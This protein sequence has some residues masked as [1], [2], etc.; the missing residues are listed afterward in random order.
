MKCKKCGTSIKKNETECK[1][2]ASGEKAPK[3]IIYNNKDVKELKLGL[4][5]KDPL[6]ISKDN[7]DKQMQSL[8]FKM[9]IIVAVLI[10]I[11]GSFLIYL[12]VSTD[13]TKVDDDKTQVEESEKKEAT[14]Y[15]RAGATEMGYI[16]IPENWSKNEEE[17]TYIYTNPTSTDQALD[18]QITF[19][20]VPINDTNVISE[21]YINQLYADKI[22]AIESEYDEQK[23]IEKKQQLAK[24]EII[25][26]TY[27][28]YQFIEYDKASNKTTYIWAVDTS[29]EAKTLITL[30]HHGDSSELPELIRSYDLAK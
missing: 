7:K 3:S 14:N 13:N 9:L 27:K 21:E 30:T 8:M 20:A 26:E 17:G 1:K 10:V 23:A 28:V 4:N 19:Q 22:K 5:V 25:L 6:T 24:A 16:N 12:L 18:E 15:I 11:A 2:C 29:K